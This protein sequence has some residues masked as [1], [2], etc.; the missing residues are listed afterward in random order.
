LDKSLDSEVESAIQSVQFSVNID[1]ISK[2]PLPDW[3]AGKECAEV[4]DAMKRVVSGPKGP[5]GK[6]SLL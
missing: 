6:G 2:L 3:M 4:E 1:E 5:D